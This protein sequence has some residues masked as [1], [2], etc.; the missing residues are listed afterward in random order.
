MEGEEGP[1]YGKPDFVL[2]D[3][4]TMEDFMKNLRLRFE[5]GRIYTYIGEVLVSVNPYQELPLYGPEAIARYQGRELYERPPHLYAVANAAYKA[6]KRRSRDTCIVISGESGAGKT[7]ASKHIMQYIA[8]VT[9]PSQR[10]EV[11]RVKDVLLKSTCIL[12]AFGNART[13]RNHNSS[14][15]GKYM[16]INFNFKGDP[17]GGH[18]HSYLLEKSRV[19]KQHVGE[20]NFH[21]FYQLL[22]GSEDQELQALHLERNPALYNFTRQGAGLS[23]GA[24]NG[25]DS[26]EKSH[27]A[28]TE[29]MRVIGFSPEEVE[30]IHRILAAILHLGNI[31]FV[32]TAED[33]LQKGGLAVT[34]E[35][36]VS[37]VAKLTATPQ[38][39]VLRSL[40]ARTVASGGRELIEKGHTV[41]EA[42]Y[43]RDACAKAVYQ[44]LFEW[45]VNR[46]N[47]IMEAR[48]RD[49][50]RDGKDTVIGVL[51]IYGFELFPVN[52][53]EQFC[54]NYCNE[55]L[56]QLFIQLILK[57]EQEE[58]EREGISWQSVEYFNNAAIV[59]LVERP[60]RGI[61]AVLD[62][63]CS[64]AGPIT[65]H[66]FLQTLDTHH[67]YHPHYCSRQLCPTDKT[68]EF[69]RDFRIKHYAGDVT[70]SVE[71]FID[72]NRDFL[73]QDFKRLFYNSMDSTLRAM[74]P[75]GQQDITEV[76]KRPLTAGTLFKNSMVALVEN[77]A[78]KEPFYVR[79]IKPNEDKVAGRLDEDHCRHQVSYLGLLENVRV[80]RAGFAFRQPYP[81]F[82]LRYKMTC[83]YTWPNHLLGSDR[84][85]VSALLEQHGL[86]GDVAF[87]HSKLFI[88]SPRTL[89]AL[90]QSR[91]RLIPII[92]LLL[93]KAWRGTLA[94]WRCRRL[95]AVYTI[96]R[97]FRRHKVHAHLAELQRRFQAAR[98]PPLYGRDL[99]WPLPPAVLQPFQDICHALFCRWRAWQLVKNIPPSDMAQIKAKVAAMGALQ[100]LR[101][102]WGCQRAWVRDYLS[103][104]TDNPTA[105][106]LFAERLKALREKDGFG[107]VLFS[108]HVR[109]VNRFHKSRDRALLLTDRHLYKLEPS[110]QYRV[111]RAVTLDM[112]TGLSVTSGR[113]QLVVLHARGQDDLVVCLHRSRPPLDNRI[114]ELVGMLASHLQAEGRALEVRV[115]DCIPLSHRGTQHHVSVQPRPEQSE[116]DFCC[117]RGTFTL[118]WPSR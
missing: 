40:L 60:H 92:V 81:R 85:A 16:D 116:P 30:S 12:E 111:M 68:M 1:E 110:R 58:Y 98:Q 83:E 75:D 45:V 34:E 44:R 67:R 43:A 32:E 9:N 103:S 94:R 35:A 38:D 99:E 4:V 50:R 87:G 10:A 101:Q 56:Q 76:T 22:R 89:V 13:N 95:R 15:F 48:G 25:L 59:E 64:T 57:Q 7:E 82:L 65:D 78:S 109:K 61:L 46:I 17:V 36:L 21:A 49:P 108:S 11:E 107:S 62:E 31:E 71:G 106:G 23:M 52:S 2:L 91:A 24:Q 70:Y 86:Q 105:S 8:A 37:H 42:S 69:G 84:A 41:A 5:T 6:M 118:L 74:W 54:I 102:D 88:R 55:K 18:I 72:K 80:R 73:F 90:E 77:L 100:G 29:A 53:F 96:M 19:L 66:I 79:C 117:S 51:D 93:Q 97:W 47:D 3:Q 112:V 114:G 26:D 115:S 39:L 20:R 104:S 33:G 28:V 27:R 63:A 14:R 113:D